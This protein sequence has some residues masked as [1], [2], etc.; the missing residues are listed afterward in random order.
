[1]LSSRLFELSRHA[2][3]AGIE[4]PVVREDE[5][6]TL[7]VRLIAVPGNPAFRAALRVYDPRRVGGS[8]RVE[9]IDPADVVIA[10]AVLPLIPPDHPFLDAPG[11][12]FIGDIGAVFPETRARSR[13][14]VRITPIG[15]T[16]F[17]AFVSVTDND[18]QQVF[19]ITTRQ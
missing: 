14:D 8:V 12:A 17:W 11:M 13:Y 4:L 16:E 7:P 6:F 1:M 9:I 5:F 10:Q 15:M 18:T 19:T 2:Q 3:P